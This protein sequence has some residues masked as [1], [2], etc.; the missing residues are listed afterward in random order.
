MSLYNAVQRYLESVLFCAEN[1]GHPYN[2]GCKHLEHFHILERQ[3][4][5]AGAYSSVSDLMK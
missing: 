3:A 1:G 2:Q 4:R 5:S